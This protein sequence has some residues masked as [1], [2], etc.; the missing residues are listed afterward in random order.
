MPTPRVPSPYR[1]ILDEHKNITGV[2]YPMPK[3]NPRP[4]EPLIPQKPV[5]LNVNPLG[6][7]SALGATKSMASYKDGVADVP[8]TGPAMLH[9]GEA[10]VP[11]KDNP[12]K[13][14][15]DKV[16]RPDT[17]KPADLAAAQATPGTSTSTGGATATRNSG[18]ATGGAVTV[19]ISGSSSTSTSTKTSTE[20]HTATGAG[21]GAGKGAGKTAPKTTDGAVNGEDESD[22]G[23][24]RPHVYNIT[25]N[26]TGRSG[27]AADGEVEHEDSEP[28]DSYKKGTDYVP[29][30]GPAVL[31]KGEAV[32]PAKE[33]KITDSSIYNKV[34]E[35]D[36]KPKKTL[37]SIHTRKAKDG[38]FIHEHNFHH[39]SHKTEE[40]TS[41]DVKAALAHMEQHAPTMEAEQAEESPAGAAGAPP[42]GAPAPAQ[43]VPAL[44]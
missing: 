41:P 43:G 36:K 10:V 37:K 28:E 32:V 2:D 42:A 33:N 38:S 4:K 23:D 39:T 16:T 25:V 30:T 40:H 26:S 3:P 44:G 31:H 17:A 1:A 6:R 34:T 27:D 13:N 11:A 7:K 14:I 20:T 22:T 19:T 8:K 18:A 29:K 15:Y 9:K 21:A 12:M 35:G 5:D 24:K